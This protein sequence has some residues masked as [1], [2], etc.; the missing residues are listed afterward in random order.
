M[1]FKRKFKW[2]FL[3]VRKIWIRGFV[4]YGL[5]HWVKFTLTLIT[6][7]I[8]T[9]DDSTF[10]FEISIYWQVTQNFSSKSGILF[11][12]TTNESFYISN[13]MIYLNSFWHWKSALI[14]CN[15]NILH[16]YKTAAE[17][18]LINQAIALDQF[19]SIWIK[20]EFFGKLF[21]R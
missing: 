18:E 14:L 4:A 7:L 9:V 5:T 15:V 3:I 21:L 19:K 20:H 6:F 17:R 12:Q 13:W 8:S 10:V 1:E 16:F 2:M 11:I